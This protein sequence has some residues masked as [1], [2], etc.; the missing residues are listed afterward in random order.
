MEEEEIIYFNHLDF[1]DTMKKPIKIC[2]TGG[3]GGTGKTLV[4]INLAVMFRDNGK[5]IL[6]LDGDV[7]NPNTY[8]L[9]GTD[10]ENG[11]NVHFFIPKVNEDKCTKCGLC[12]KNCASNAILFVKDAYPII[13]PNVCSGCKLCYKICPVNAIEENSK[14]IGKIYEKKLE[15]MAL[16]FD[17][18]IYDTAPGAHCDVEKLIKE[19]DLV[20][21]V[22]EPTPF[23]KLDLMRI[24]ELIELMEKKYKVIINRSSLLGFKDDFIKDLKKKK[25]DILGEI[26]LDQEIVNSYCQGIPLMAKNS[27]Y[28]MESPG[29][30]AFE[31]IFSKL[32]EWVKDYGK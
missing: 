23:G 17:I 10:L 29:A 28:D 8:L 2:V 5:K 16:L 1:R 26:P 11:E 12:A 14:I 15:N 30:K 31:N 19:A 27:P 21:P 13:I 20:I 32:N 22:T 18:I 9:L 7:E 25:I 24:I 4:A 3:K 6:L